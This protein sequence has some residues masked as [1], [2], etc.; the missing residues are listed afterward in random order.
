MKNRIALLPLILLVVLLTGIIYSQETTNKITVNVDS[1]EHTI[2][3]N[4]YGHFAEHLGRCIY[5]GIWVGEDSPIPNIR[6][7]RKDVVEALQELEI[8]VLRWP[9][10]CFADIYHWRDGIG[11]KQER[12]AT[13]NMFWGGVIEDNSFGTHEFLDLCEL[14]DTEPYL[15]VNVG[16][17]TPQEA[18]DWVEYVTSDENTPMANL[19]RKNGREKPWKVTYWGIGN[20]NW[21]C[22]G[23]MTA[24]YY[25]DLYKRFSTYCWVP[26][27]IASGSYGDEYE[28]TETLMKK[29][30]DRK[31]LIQ[32]LSFHHYSFSESSATEFN[33]N[34]WLLTVKNNMEVEGMLKKHIAIMDKYDPENEIALLADEWGNWHEVEPGT[35]PGFLYQQNSLR[36]AVTAA[37]Y[38]NTF[39][40]LCHRVK[41][42]NIAQTVNV[43]Q[44]MVLTNPTQLIKTPTF[45]VF[46][47]YKVHFDA[48]MLPVEV[49]AEKYGEGENDFPTLSVSAS[50]NDKEEINITVANVTYDRKMPTEIVLDGI[51]NFSVK[52]SKIIT[53][54]KMNSY[55][56]FG[57]E[58]E[59]NIA[60]FNG[61]KKVNNGLIVDIPSKS[62]LL[63]TLGK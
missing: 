15:A 10:G 52:G 1:G 32:G 14:L 41:M 34:D 8:P 36:D 2:N 49:D 46:K 18:K 44:A 58:E 33:E 63:I 62:V 27:K 56:D 21:G 16:S 26:Y 25:A 17:S 40:N 11:P 3:R 39:N 50:K 55:N 43:L 5:D 29:T 6:G 60:E 28:W 4:I 9:G 35:N 22:G 20:E 57:K 59:V 30:Q 47:M 19:R 12:P 54:D 51:E 38:L 61:V 23:N 37:I 31:D 48:L 45:Y 7:Y 13:K 53:A 42:A 24:D